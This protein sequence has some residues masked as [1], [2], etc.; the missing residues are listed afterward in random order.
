MTLDQLLQQ[1]RAGH[2]IVGAHRCTC[3]W[4]GDSPITHIVDLLG[5]EEVGLIHQ[6]C[7]P[8]GC[9]HFGLKVNTFH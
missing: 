8:V 1:I 3:G 7:D 4:E 5:L 2:M 6:T 9:P